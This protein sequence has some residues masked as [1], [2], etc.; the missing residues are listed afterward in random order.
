MGARTRKRG[1]GAEPVSGCPGRRLP[2]GARAGEEGPRSRWQRPRRSPDWVCKDARRIALSC[3]HPTKSQWGPQ[4]RRLNRT[5]AAWRY[6]GFRAEAGVAHRSCTRTAAGRP[7]WRN[8]L[9]RG[10][11]LPG[12]TSLLRC[13][14]L[15][16]RSLTVPVSALPSEPRVREQADPAEARLHLPRLSAPQGCRLPLYPSPASR[17]GDILRFVLRE[18]PTAPRGLLVPKAPGGSHGGVGGSL[19]I[20][21]ASGRLY[22]AEN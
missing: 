9:K 7:C 17:R 8:R 6:R 22:A 5:K 13:P 20:R 11:L 1:G 15:E 16:R 14:F 2:G 10:V 12:L 21:A 18:G 3:P 4:P 19:R